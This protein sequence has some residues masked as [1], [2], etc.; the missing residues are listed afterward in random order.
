ML[1]NIRV[2]IY[3]HRLLS[4]HCESRIAPCT[5]TSFNFMKF[6]K[7]LGV[8]TSP[9]LFIPS[10]KIVPKRATIPKAI[11]AK[12]AVVLRSHSTLLVFLSRN[13]NTYRTLVT[14]GQTKSELSKV[15]GKWMTAIAQT[16]IDYRNQ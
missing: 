7:S 9:T 10:S 13:P 15:T 11:R 6:R 16:R 8:N 14:T 4:E 2:Q 12:K 3:T 1:G 5:R